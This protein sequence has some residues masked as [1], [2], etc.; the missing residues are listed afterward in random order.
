MTHD[1][2]STP[3]TDLA[4]AVERCRDVADFLAVWLRTPRLPPREQS[5]LEAYY[6]SYIR[7]FPPRV[8]RHFAEQTREL[9]QTLAERPGARVLE[10]GC[11]CGTESLWMALHG[12][13]VHG[14][15]IRNDR[16]EVARARRDVLS[17]ALGVELRCTFEDRSLFDLDIE[18]VDV[19]WM[20]NTFHHLEPRAQV[21]RRI[22]RLLRPGGRVI[23]AEANA[24]NV[25]LQLALLR[26]RGL[27]TV[28]VFVDADGRRHPYG[29]ERITTAKRL[30]GLFAREGIVCRSTRHFRMFP[31]RPIFDRLAPIERLAEHRY[32]RPLATTYTYVGERPAAQR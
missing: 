7:H 14:I 22:A 27:K 12:A 20:E 25:P 23:V 32:L 21:V 13:T 18:P 4:L 28:D 3:S 26:Q 24:L 1:D 15:D 30:A 11:G 17:R 29:V 2:T 10:V 6:G 5:V 8:R 19:V 9:M 31:N 16:L